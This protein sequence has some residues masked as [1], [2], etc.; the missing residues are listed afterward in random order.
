MEFSALGNCLFAYWVIRRNNL[1][2]LRVINI[3]VVGA[4]DRVGPQNN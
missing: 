4:K 2:H 3:C 1:K